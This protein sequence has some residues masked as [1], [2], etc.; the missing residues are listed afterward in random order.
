M[1]SCGK[2]V[3]M[4]GEAA[5]YPVIVFA[6]EIAVMYAAGS[7]ATGRLAS[8]WISA[9]P[10]QPPRQSSAR[11]TGLATVARAGAGFAGAPLFYAVVFPGVVLHETAH[12]LACLVSGTEVGRFSPFSPRKGADGRI[13]LGQVVH[14]DRAAPIN[15]FIGLA[16]V[17]L[18]PLG[19]LACVALLSPLSPA[20]VFPPEIGVL[21]EWLVAGGFASEQPVRAAV[22][23][24]LSA[25]FALGS[26]PSRED[27]RSIPGAALL[28]ALLAAAVA[29]VSPAWGA[30]AA[31]TLSDLAGSAST[32]YALPAAVSLLAAL[33]VGVAVGARRS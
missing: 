18:N 2:V 4:V 19:I 3:P 17:V 13:I 26:V 16:P 30:A 21:Y 6:T 14:A 15:A 11:G 9:P 24:Y 22:C 7:Y 32:L 25:S 1:C 10:R 31:A 12:F 33:V 23:V 29:L 20:E 27:L 8:V 28:V 5:L